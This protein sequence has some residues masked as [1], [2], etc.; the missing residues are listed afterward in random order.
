MMHLER[1]SGKD[2]PVIA[3]ALV[4]MGGAPMR[5]FAAAR[6]LWA[7]QDSFQSPGPIQVGGCVGGCGVLM[8]RHAGGGTAG[9]L[10]SASCQPVGLLI[11]IA[12]NPTSLPPLPSHHL[13][14]EG[15]CADEAN[16][17]LSLEVNGGAPILLAEDDGCA[18]CGRAPDTRA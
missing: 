1:R 6:P 17:T 14:F 7:I 3:K 16:I 9:A 13:Q 12:L 5:A 4:E 10:P 8:S 18:A 15:R 11:L 2:K